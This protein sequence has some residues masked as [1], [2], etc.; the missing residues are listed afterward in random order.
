MLEAVTEERSGSGVTLRSLVIGAGLSLVIG[1]GVPY[2]VFIVL[3]TDM[4]LT[5]NTPA[6]F[7]LF[8]LW[9]GVVQVLLGMIDRRL[10]L[11][12]AELLT[13]YIMMIVAT[14]IPSR[15]FTVMLLATISGVF[16][17][18]TPENRWAELVHPYLPEWMIPQDEVGLQYLFEG[19]PGGLSIP[20]G[21]WWRPLFWW[22]L[23]MVAFWMVTI[24]TMVILRR[25]WVEHE[26]LIF[27]MT[28]VPLAMV[29]ASSGGSL[30]TSFFKS[31]LMWVGLLLTFGVGSFNALHHYFPF[32]PRIPRH[33]A[34]VYVFRRTT[35]VHFSLNFMMLGF[36]YF[37]KADVMLGLWVFYLLRVVEH[38]ALSMLGLGSVE[39]LAPFS[40]WGGVQTLLGHQMAGAMIVLVLFGL[41]IARGH[42]REVFRKALRGDD[43]V[44][45]SDEILS[46]RATVL[47][48]IVGLVVMALWLW[49]AGLP[50]WIVPLFLFGSLMVFIAL[51]RLLVETGLPT[52]IPRLIPC[53][54]VISGI[55]VRH[56]GPSGMIAMSST[57]VWGANLLIFLMAPV[58]NG[59][60]LSGEILHRKRWLF[61]A[62]AIA[63]GVAATSS[64]VTTM[65]L[66]YRDGGVNLYQ[67]YFMS[68]PT[69]PWRYAATKINENAGPNGLGW[70]FTVIGGTVTA[71][72]MLLRR[73]FLWWPLH[74]LGFVS[75]VRDD[76]WLAIF[77]AWLI[78]S[79]ILKYGGVKAYHAARPFFWGLILGQFV[80]GGIWLI[81]DYFSG[82]TGNI[83][84]VF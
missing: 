28:K 42:L 30:V 70:V 51:T 13:I 79:V 67:H 56:M 66:A 48:L 76:C 33:L 26:H 18:A 22:L 37:L 19:L 7:F 50:L 59:L 52:M 29:E 64:W 58:A 5:S 3:G 6:A 39:R 77:V 15:G 54:V 31:R 8:F 74:P 62:M 16:Y 72:L 46:Y 84:P 82:V 60:K 69:Y 9:V 71:V 43:R 55:G 61:A 49:R 27:P 41:W 73:R 63:I 81:V 21:I 10:A 53:D 65:R 78:K 36:A 40:G 68:Y 32:L 44:G 83:I 17:Y 4:A 14:A 45:D 20:W 57:F 11:N 25:Q 23:F 2:G 47:G 24:C 12:R 38:G 35:V 75:W 80:A 34:S 1:I